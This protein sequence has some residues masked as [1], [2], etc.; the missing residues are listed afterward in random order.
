M[1]SSCLCDMFVAY[2]MLL[3]PS[4][5]LSSNSKECKSKAFV[6]CKLLFSQSTPLC[7]TTAAKEE[8]GCP[9]AI[10]Y[11]LSEMGTRVSDCGKK[12]NNNGL[13][14]DLEVQKLASGSDG[15]FSV[16]GAHEV[17][18]NPHSVL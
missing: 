10:L 7:A 15:G 4:G 9:W 6:L 14:R 3:S 17:S 8:L 16:R 2:L 5:H 11:T 13:L 12:D 18:N 1:K